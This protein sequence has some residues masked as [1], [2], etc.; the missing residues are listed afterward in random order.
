MKSCGMVLKK[1]GVVV[2]ASNQDSPEFGQISEIFVL[3]PQ[4]I[5]LGLKLMEVLEYS[6]HYHSWLVRE[7][8]TLYVTELRNLVSLHILQPRPMCNAM[9]VV[10]FVALKYSVL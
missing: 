3:S 6:S 4:N 8:E 5:I 7:T 2:T 9:A 10:N 1:G